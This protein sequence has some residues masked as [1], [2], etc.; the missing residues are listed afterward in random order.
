MGTCGAA[1]EESVGIITTLC[2]QLTALV[3][4]RLSDFGRFWSVGIS[5]SAKYEPGH[6]WP[7]LLTWMKAWSLTVC[8]TF[9]PHLIL[10]QLHYTDVI[11]S[12]V[13]TSLTI[14]YST[15]YS[16]TNQRKFQSSA[17]LAFVLGIHRWPVNSQHK[18]PVTRKKFP[19]DDV[20]MLLLGSIDV[21]LP[22]QEF[23]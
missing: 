20:I 15:V 22:V 21:P 18:W 23:T 19:F 5:L 1:I 9:P 17:S 7:L 3:F 16:G 14:V 2:F 13:I 8:M 4:Y 6:Q 10:T 11:M 12:A